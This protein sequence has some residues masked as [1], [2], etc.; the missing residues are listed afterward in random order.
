[1]LY[2]H[3]V[4]W[5]MLTRKLGNNCDKGNHDPVSSLYTACN[6]LLYGSA[7][8]QFVERWLERLPNMNSESPAFS[9]VSCLAHWG[10]S[11]AFLQ[12]PTGLCCS[13]EVDLWLTTSH[14]PVLS[15]SD[16]KMHKALE[17]KDELKIKK[18]WHLPGYMRVFLRQSHVDGN[19]F[20]N[21]QIN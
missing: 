12:P 5:N 20:Q 21:A 1:M 2:K 14:T 6:I 11:R 4:C 10:L 8:A 7:I 17:L 19:M 9:R 13:F 15:R 18:Q 16:R 3:Y